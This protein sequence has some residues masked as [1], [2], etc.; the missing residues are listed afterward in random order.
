MLRR[1]LCGIQ[2]GKKGQARQAADQ[3]PD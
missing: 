2:P 1:E 3:V